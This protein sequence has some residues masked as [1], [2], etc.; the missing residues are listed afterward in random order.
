MGV[1]NDK[2]HLWK[3]DVSRSVDLYNEWF[4]EFAPQTYRDTRMRTTTDVESALMLT[5]VPASG[6]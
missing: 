6:R 4:M 1:N 3:A 2:T 5:T